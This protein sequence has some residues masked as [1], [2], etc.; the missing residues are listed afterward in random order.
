MKIA[1]IVASINSKSNGLGGHYYSLLETA[2]QISKKHEVIIINVGNQAAKA[3]E[4]TNIKT[5]RVIYNGLALHKTYTHIKYIINS[6][7]PDVLH[8]FDVL[9]FFWAR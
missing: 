9:A 4:R 6:E 2:N 1:F 8:A 3:L 7:R 5:F